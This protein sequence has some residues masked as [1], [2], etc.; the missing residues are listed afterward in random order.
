LSTHT[1][2]LQPVPLDGDEGKGRLLSLDP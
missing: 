1:L 2:V